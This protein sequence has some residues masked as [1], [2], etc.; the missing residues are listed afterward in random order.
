MYLRMKFSDLDK[1]SKIEHIWEYYKIPIIGGISGLV[2]VISLVT[3]I[4]SNINTEIVLDVTFI[5]K[6]YD[7]TEAN[8]FLDEF[9]DA[10]INPEAPKNQKVVFEFI[11]I[12]ENLSPDQLMAYTTKLFAKSSGQLLDILIVDKEQ[13]EQYAVEGMFISLNDIIKSENIVVDESRL[14]YSKTE[15]DTE[16]KIYG[17]TIENNDNI[18]AICGDFSEYVAAV[19]ID[20]QY[21]ENAIK[22]L[23]E[24]VK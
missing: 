9:D 13:F 21:R 3:S 18:D 5:T 1:K 2:L 11:N 8:L 17:I 16:E 23:K 22:A 7:D 19:Y 24:L 6:Y 20:E 4:V 12:S 15:E 14:V 10:F